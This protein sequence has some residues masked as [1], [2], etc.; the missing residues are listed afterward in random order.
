MLGSSRLCLARKLAAVALGACMVTAT[1]AAGL[2]SHPVA[3]AVKRGDCDAAIGLV[4]TGV[5][6]NDPQAAFLGGRM[7]DEG[8]CVVQN[9]EAAA[10]FFE[11]A[12]SLGNKDA[13]LEYAA[14]VGLGEGAEQSY[15]RAGELCRAAGLD[16]QA[17]LS[18]YSLGYACTLRSV[19]GRLLRVSLPA[20]AFRP[21]TGTAV[22][23]FRPSGSTIR[24]LSAPRV[25]RESEPS[26]GSH[27]GRHQVDAQRAIEVAWRNALAAVP[28]PDA[29]HLEAQAVELSLDA[30]MTLEN[31]AGA[32][33][34]LGPPSAELPFPAKLNNFPMGAGH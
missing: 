15:E 12:A 18:G 21:G 25:E 17:H 9:H 4:K 2:S 7:L 26:I 30:E 13:S 34:S 1:F 24:V 20:G 27:M 11:L 23:E 33:K 10:R 5:A 28:K 3:T 16:P 19:A 29:G 6:S 14:K 32:D 22:V 8:V 31:G